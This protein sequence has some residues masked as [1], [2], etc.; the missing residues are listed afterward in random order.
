MRFLR[1]KRFIQRCQVM[2]VQLITHQRDSFG[3]QTK[4][5]HD[6]LDEMR[7]LLVRATLSNGHMT[8]TACWLKGDKQI[9][10]PVRS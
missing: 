4:T 5:I 7:P 2:G 3:R 8:L 10:C 1:R 6:V 9:A